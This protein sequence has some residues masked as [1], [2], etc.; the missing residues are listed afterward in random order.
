MIHKWQLIIV[1]TPSSPIKIGGSGDFDLPYCYALL[2]IHNCRDSTVCCPRT[3]KEDRT[4][5]C[6]YKI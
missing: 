3:M 6:P 5:S 4:V 1:E 2:V